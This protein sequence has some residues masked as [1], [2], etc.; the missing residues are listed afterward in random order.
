MMPPPRQKSGQQPLQTP[1]VDMGVVLP[2]LAGGVSAAY[3]PYTLMDP[4]S[5]GAGENTQAWVADPAVEPTG[6]W[7]TVPASAADYAPAADGMQW[8]QGTEAGASASPPSAITAMAQTV[9]FAF[10]EGE[11]NAVSRVCVGVTVGPDA[12]AGGRWDLDLAAVVGGLPASLALQWTHLAN[13]ADALN[14]DV[15]ALSNALDITWTGL[16]ATPSV[17]WVWAELVYPEGA[18]VTG[19][20]AALRVHGSTDLAT[21]A[22]LQFFKVHSDTPAALQGAQDVHVSTVAGQYRVTWGLP[23]LFPT[24]VRRWVVS[25]V[26]D[27]RVA[28][29]S[30]PAVTRAGL[31]VASPAANLATQQCH[32]CPPVAYV[33]APPLPG[34]PAP[35]VVVPPS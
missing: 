14:W 20:Q 4:A 24:S 6:P 32:P 11:L 16:G 31:L 1:A 18:A 21:D 2:T 29:V 33:Q 12:V 35:V 22:G 26:A 5:A 34:S 27:P 13:K 25:D 7:S 23:P 3:V 19:L 30:V 8:L 28:P 9:Q 15:H 10:P 17:L